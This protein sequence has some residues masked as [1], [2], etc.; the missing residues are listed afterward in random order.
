VSS[1]ARASS[2]IGNRGGLVVLVTGCGSGIGLATA[3]EAA[4]AGH[5][6]YAGMRDLASAPALGAAAV[7]LPITP[8][9][10]DVTHPQERVAAVER[11]VRDHGRLDVLVNNAGIALGG[12]L[13]QVDEDEIRHVLDVNLIGTWAMTRA[14]LPHLRAARGLVVLM[15]STAGRSAM[16]GMGVYAASKFAL[17]AVGEAFRHELAPFGVR[18]VLVEPGAHRTAIFGRNR[19]LSR[20]ARDAASPYAPYVDH[21]DALVTRIADRWARDPAEVARRVVSLFGVRRPALRH[22]VGPD[23]RIRSWL[24]RLLPFSFFE[25]VVSR[26]LRGR[27]PRER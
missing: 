13:E 6:V 5:A 16:P 23:A 22:P 25:W 11:V 19:R 27:V 7:G 26:G 12:F 21:L 10:L 24:L 20:H 14:A 8:L 17:E 4:R 1:E 3:V 2:G 9:A 15:S 18:V